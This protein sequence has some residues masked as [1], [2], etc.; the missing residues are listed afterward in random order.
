M[1]SPCRTLL[2]SLIAAGAC[3]AALAQPA[4]SPWY[5]EVGLARPTFKAD[6]G[7]LS[8]RAHPDLLTGTIGYQ[9][10]PNLAVEGFL[11]GG[12][13]SD[14]IKVNGATSGADVKVSSA[15]GVFFKPSIHL[16]ERVELFGR[17]GYV[18]THLRLTAG[19]VNVEGHRDDAAYGLGVNLNLNPRSYIQANWTNYHDKG[20]VNV[21]GL[22]VMYG[23]RF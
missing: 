23:R 1:N 3:S 22:G 17:L 16:G 20:K 12:V 7:A 8:A 5:G 18:R 13:S 2:T 6:D 10:L 4:D 21:E 15:Y 19:L 9:W 14:S 11:A